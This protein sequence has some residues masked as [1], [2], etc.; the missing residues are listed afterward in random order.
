MN[1]M[2]TMSTARRSAGAFHPMRYTVPWP[3]CG[4]CVPLARGHRQ[5]AC[6][7]SAVWHRHLACVRGANPAAGFAACRPKCEVLLIVAA[8]EV[9]AR[10]LLACRAGELHPYGHAALF[11]RLREVLAPD[12]ERD[13]Y[14]RAGAGRQ[15]RRPPADALLEHLVRDLAGNPRTGT[16]RQLVVEAIGTL[17]ERSCAAPSAS[18]TARAA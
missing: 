17:R 10:L 16:V 8:D 14:D 11:A 13:V 6:A 9:G 7:T 1:S 4:T 3:N 5:D 18:D 2:L 15:A 12:L